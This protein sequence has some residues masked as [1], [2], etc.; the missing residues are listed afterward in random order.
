[1]RHFELSV[2]QLEGDGRLVC[3][4]WEFDESQGS[5]H[6]NLYASADT[7]GSA[8]QFGPPALSGINGETCKII[9]LEGNQIL[10]L[11]WRIDKPGL[12]GCGETVAQ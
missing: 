8:V 12:W 2:T 10:A 3:T 4:A 6:A 9:A 11:Y 7:S 5:S 1:M